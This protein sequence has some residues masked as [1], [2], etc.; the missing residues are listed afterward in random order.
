MDRSFLLDTVRHISGYLEMQHEK[1]GAISEP[2][3]FMI[4]LFE[5]FFSFSAVT[6]QQNLFHRTSIATVF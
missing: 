1:N 6:R 2:V 3:Y 4:L 5:L